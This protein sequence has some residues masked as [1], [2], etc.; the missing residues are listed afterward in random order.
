[1]IVVFLNGFQQDIKN[2]AQSWIEQLTLCSSGTRST[3]ELL[4]HHMYQDLNPNCKV[5]ETCRLPLSYTCIINRN[6]NLYI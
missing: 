1:M 3:T 5:L 4:S 6:K 2:M